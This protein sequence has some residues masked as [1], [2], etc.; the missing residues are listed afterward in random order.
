MRWPVCGH[1]ARATIAMGSGFHSSSA[2]FIW[3]RAHGFFQIYKHEVAEKLYVRTCTD[4]R[5]FCALKW[6]RSMF[7]FCGLDFEIENFQDDK[8]RSS[9]GFD[10][11][12]DMVCSW[13]SIETV[14]YTCHPDNMKW[15]S[16]VEVLEHIRPR[17]FQCQ[18]LAYRWYPLRRATVAGEC[19]ITAQV[20]PQVF[21][22]RPRI[23]CAL[24]PRD[25]YVKDFP[26]MVLH[27]YWSKG[28][29]IWSW[30][31]PF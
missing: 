6:H 28:E 20:A 13:N 17:R 15:I 22:K 30:H 10:T 8:H 18:V 9:H 21:K 11:G 12:W 16:N 1:L 25:G 26:C 19:H 29:K 23:R 27:Q 2:L 24:D 14:S 3:I 5:M 31:P 4:A 7:S